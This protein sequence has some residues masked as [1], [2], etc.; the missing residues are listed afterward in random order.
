MKPCGAYVGQHSWSERQENKGVIH[1]TLVTC[2]SDRTDGCMQCVPQVDLACSHEEADTRLLFHAQHASIE[3]DDPI[4]IHS[5]DTYVLV[6]AAFLCGEDP[7]Y[8]PLIFRVCLHQQAWG[9]ISV[10]SISRKLDAHVCKGLPDMHAFGVCDS[11]SQ[12]AGHGKKTTM[13]LLLENS[14][15]LEA[16][17]SLGSEFV[18]TENTLQQAE[19]SICI[20][21]NSTQYISTNDVRNSKWNRS[22]KNITKLPQ[23]HDSAVLHI[24]RA[25]YQAAIW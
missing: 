24:R 5:P 3:S 2:T 15:F 9:Y 25:N 1:L 21:Y 12:F 6:L 13:K 10:T 17:C 18:P 11:T 22:A 4:L 16:M 8:F 20:M 19:R 7:G 14:D 23:C